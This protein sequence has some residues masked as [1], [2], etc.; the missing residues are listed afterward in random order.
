MATNPNDIAKALNQMME[1]LK[2]LSDT[3]LASVEGIIKQQKKLLEDD[4][5]TK[6]A[7]KKLERI[8]KEN[9]KKDVQIEKEEVKTLK[10][11]KNILKTLTEN[12][13]KIKTKNFRMSFD[14]SPD[15]KDLFKKSFY[16]SLFVKPKATVTQEKKKSQSLNDYIRKSDS[17]DV[18]E[19]QL[20]VLREIDSKIDKLSMAGSGSIFDLLLNGVQGMLSKALGLSL[21]GLGAAGGVGALGGLGKLGGLLK[22]VGKAGRLGRLAKVAGGALKAKSPIL[23]GAILAG[24][25]G[26]GLYKSFSNDDEEENSEE[27]S[28]RKSGGVVKSDSMYL[29][30]ERGPEL[31][32]PD[33]NGSIIPNHKLFK[34]DDVKTPKNFD[35][36]YINDFKEGFN[37]NLGLLVGKFN[38][39]FKHFGEVISDG[40]G[41]WFKN[42]KDDIKSLVERML[43]I[44]GTAIDKVK[45]IS[46]NIIDKVKDLFK[47]PPD[48]VPK[49]E[50]KPYLYNVNNPNDFS[51]LKIPQPQ[52][53]IQSNPSDNKSED[54]GNVVT[55]PV[56]EN[57]V[58]IKSIPTID[59][60]S[61]LTQE[62]WLKEFIPSFTTMIKIKPRV[63]NNVYKVSS[64]PFGV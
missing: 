45:E 58:D 14:K 41:D 16:K 26:Y 52:I 36:S 33:S 5:K 21:G 51:T 62:F 46:G 3:Q 4:K 19:E 23:M 64:D 22:G 61:D 53:T 12:V 28:P 2:E 37:K 6:D 42:V 25:L 40:V 60:S 31:F 29:V 1:T 7:V 54:L 44:P 59:Y 47:A 55:N 27:V 50:S 13:E 39:S 11:K 24:G 63:Q 8:K 48:F 49:T 18:Q 20:K 35:V 34:N 57:N 15:V 56:I 38:D 43:K 17:G 30:G 9:K 32:S 10:L